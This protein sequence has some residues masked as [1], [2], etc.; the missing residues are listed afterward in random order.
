[1]ARKKISHTEDGD[2]LEYR[3]E[4][5]K[6]NIQKFMESTFCMQI[7]SLKK[8]HCLQ[9]LLLVITAIFIMGY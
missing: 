1:M 5:D 3:A 9:Y 6:M 7:K 8:C 2:N 4:W